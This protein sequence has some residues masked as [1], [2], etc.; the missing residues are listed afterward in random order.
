MWRLQR[1][2]QS[3]K[4]EWVVELSLPAREYSQRSLQSAKW[5]STAGRSTSSLDPHKLQGCLNDRLSG[6]I[7]QKDYRAGGSSHIYAPGRHYSPNRRRVIPVTQT[8]E[9]ES[10]LWQTTATQKSRRTSL[11]I[12]VQI[13]PFWRADIPDTSG[14]TFSK[15]I[16][17]GRNPIPGTW[18]GMGR[19]YNRN[20]GLDD[21]AA[22]RLPQGK[23]R[24]RGCRPQVWLSPQGHQLRRHQRVYR[25][26]EAQ[27]RSH[28]IRPQGR[29]LRLRLYRTRSP[30]GQQ[31]RFHA[32]K[33][34]GGSYRH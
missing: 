25:A 6:Y 8:F 1:S 15:Q 31:A 22:A 17:H 11:E 10:R 21:T 33:S 5:Y 14:T 19:E 3:I 26:A 29:R 13:P 7:L 32:Q 9:R 27:G 2:T 23:A 30:R 20:P 18:P 24:R 28:H 16:E 12:L 4:W 34:R